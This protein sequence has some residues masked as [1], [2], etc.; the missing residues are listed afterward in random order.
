MQTSCA[1]YGWQT[2]ARMLASS[3]SAASG[4]NF[5]ERMLIGLNGGVAYAEGEDRWVTIQPAWRLAVP[6]SSVRVTITGTLV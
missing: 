2:E 5:T 4:L 3:A 1:A 6:L